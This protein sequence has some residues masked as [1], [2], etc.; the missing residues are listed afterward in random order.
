M[1]SLPPSSRR[2]NPSRARV[3]VRAHAQKLAT[4]AAVVAGA[5]VLLPSVVACDPLNG[6]YVCE[7]VPAVDARYAA[8]GTAI[9]VQIAIDGA[10]TVYAPDAKDVSGAA[11]STNTLP[12]SGTLV[13]RLLPDEGAT[14]IT[15]TVRFECAD[16]TGT[17]TQRF[18]LDLPS[19]HAPGTPVTATFE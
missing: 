5:S 8:D 9:D 10:D 19:T 7:G 6:P 1:A 17:D 15:V 14:M 3:R 12:T 18:T 13:L 11:I 16:G 2:T 4:A